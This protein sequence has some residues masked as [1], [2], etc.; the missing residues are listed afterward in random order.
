MSLTLADAKTLIAGAEAAAI[1][2]DRKVSIVVVNARALPIMMQCMDDAFWFTPGIATA[3]ARTSV[4]MNADSGSLAG[5][6]ADLPGVWSL[7]EAQ[8]AYPITS[9]GGGVVIHTD[10]AVAGAI[11]VS[12]ASE[13]E[14]IE[15]AKAGIVAWR[16][17]S[18]A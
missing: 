6:Q 3:K 13:E 14:D 1:A 10:G 7:I 11:A 5:L 15:I 4:D 16:S 2:M 18:D 12:G 9:L 8:V 17:S